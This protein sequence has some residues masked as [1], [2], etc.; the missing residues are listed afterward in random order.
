MNE[1]KSTEPFPFRRSISQEDSD[2]QLDSSSDG[3]GADWI[4]PRSHRY[5]SPSQRKTPQEREMEYLTIAHMRLQ[6]THRMHLTESVSRFQSL[7]KHYSQE[8]ERL[9]MLVERLQ[10][11]NRLLQVELDEAAKNAR[12]WR[13]EKQM[14]AEYEFLAGQLEFFHK[15]LVNPSAFRNNLKNTDMCSNFSFISTGSDQSIKASRG[16]SSE[17]VLVHLDRE[18]L[19][20]RPG[21][22]ILELK[23]E[24]ER[25]HKSIAALQDRIQFLETA[26]SNVE[27]RLQEKL[28]DEQYLRKEIQLKD[29]VLAQIEAQYTELERQFEILGEKEPSVI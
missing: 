4:V 11:A 10:R 27:G 26:K 2:T 6:Q 29:S 24:N 8:T 14:G 18:T 25:L 28:D 21:D 15:Q 19:A 3:D 22:L 1:E 12:K 17:E 5:S 9:R 13:Q 7:S 16:K 20:N 23:R